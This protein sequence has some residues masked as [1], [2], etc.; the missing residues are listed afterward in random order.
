MGHVLTFYLALRVPKGVSFLRSPFG[1]P[2]GSV[3]YLAL[4]CPWPTSV[5]PGEWYALPQS[6]Q[7]YLEACLRNALL[8]YCDPLF[9]SPLFHFAACSRASGTRCRSRPSCVL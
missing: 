6:L 7:L 5:Q 3:S 2:L 8:G 4:S 1:P 9:P